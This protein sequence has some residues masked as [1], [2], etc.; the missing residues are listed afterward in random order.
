MAGKG[1]VILGLQDPAEHEL[2]AGAARGE[3]LE[4]RSLEETEVLEES[5]LPTPCMVVLDTRN[6]RPNAY[7]TA[8]YLKDRHGVRT[9]LL[10]DSV[11]RDEAL[12][13][14]SCAGARVLFRPLSP[15]GTASV[16]RE[17]GGFRDRP[18]TTGLLAEKERALDPEVFSR[19]VL[20]GLSE[21]EESS[22]SMVRSLLDPETGL[23]HQGFMKLR[24]EEEVKRARRF[25]QV[26][27]LVVIHLEP[28][29]SWVQGPPP[30]ELLL[31][32]SGRLLSETRDIDLLG[33]WGESALALLLP[34]TPPEGAAAM[35]RRV[36]PDAREILAGAGGWKAPVG[37]ARA[38][39]K[40]IQTGRDLLAG[41]LHAMEE[42]RSSLGGD[43]LVGLSGPRG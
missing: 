16:L 35:V 28:P 3:G 26:L 29:P 39:A 14:G 21:W 32:L 20:E 34:G 12:T 10:A 30:A 1:L 42:A 25:H 24:M 18:S 27:T 40:G 33:R 13:L 6:D 9:L 8:L 7:E 19:R 17:E 5:S 41:A 22:E 36:F 23:F 11:L 2:F 15:G 4:V 37:L 38:P 43:D 31:A